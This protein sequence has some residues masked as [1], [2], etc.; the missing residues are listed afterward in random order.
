MIFTEFRNVVFMLLC[1]HIHVDTL[2][3][4]HIFTFSSDKKKG[5]WNESFEMFVTQRDDFIK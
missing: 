3:R 1:R 4:R 2:I 5:K